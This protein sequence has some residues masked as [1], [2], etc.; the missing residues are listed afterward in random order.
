[1]TELNL[2]LGWDE[3]DDIRVIVASG[4]PLG[5]YQIGEIR[6]AMNELG[7]MSG[8]VGV[9]G[10]KELL[11]Q[12]QDAQDVLSGKNVSE[13]G[14]V[15]VK[16]DVLEWEASSGQNGPEAEIL[17]IRGLLRQYFSFSRLFNEGYSGVTGLVRS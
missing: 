14:R 5:R 7:D 1:M 6:V 11:G 13:D 15:L 8:E 9:S 12:F 4:L 16:A 3:G 10:V 17:R 2:S